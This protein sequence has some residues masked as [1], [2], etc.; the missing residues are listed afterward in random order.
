LKEFNL[1]KII[2]YFES[3]NWTI[4]FK[5]TIHDVY[6]FWIKVKVFFTEK[7]HWEYQFSFG[8]CNE[9]WKICVGIQTDPKDT[10]SRQ[11]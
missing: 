11:S 4:I 2:L 3:H 7:E 1:V 9:E 6:T 5:Q 10:S 8:S